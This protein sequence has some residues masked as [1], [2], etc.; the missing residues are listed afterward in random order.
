M[1][2]FRKQDKAGELASRAAFFARIHRE[3]SVASRLRRIVQERMTWRKR[4]LPA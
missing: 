3:P 2:A 1:C 4:P